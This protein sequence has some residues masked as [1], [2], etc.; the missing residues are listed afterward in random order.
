M[1]IIKAQ[2]ELVNANDLEE[3]TTKESGKM[4]YAG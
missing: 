2:I 1:G 3:L 4:K